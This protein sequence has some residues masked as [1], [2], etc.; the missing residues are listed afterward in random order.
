MKVRGWKNIFHANGKQKK[1]GV[2]ILISDKID[3]KI[4]ITSDKEG[5][6]I[7]IKG[8]IQEEDITIVNIY[9]PNIGA[10]QYIRQTL[11]DIKGETDSNIIIVG[12]FNTPLTP[13]DRSSKQKISREIQVLNDILDEMYLIDI[14]R[15]FHPKAEEY[16]VFSSAHGTFSRIDH[17]L[18]HK[19]NLSKFTKI[20]IVSN[21]FS[22]HN[23]M[24]LRINYKKNKTVRNTNTWRLNNTFLNNQQITE[25]IKRESKNF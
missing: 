1:A 12:D 6:Y 9:A 14:F 4:K 5:H 10:P 13:M 23:A 25:K 3:L 2:A 21:I 22:D 8:S 7:M 16:T 19:S 24:R 11:T 18:G 17:I 15:S 20:E